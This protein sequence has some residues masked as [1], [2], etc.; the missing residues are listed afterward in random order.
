MIIK[1][2]KLISISESDIKKGV[3]VIPNKVTEINDEVILDFDNLEKVIAKGV[4]TI[5]NYNFRYCNALT[6]IDIPLVTTIGNDNF[7]YCNAL[8]SI[9]IP[10]VTTIGNDNFRYCNAL[11]SIDIPL[12]TTIGNDNFRYCNALTSIDIPL[13]TT[14][15]NYNFYECNALTSIDIPL[16]TTIGNDNFYECNALTSIDIPL[17]TTIGNDNFYECNALTSIKTKKYDLKIKCVDKIPFVIENE[18]TTKGI[19]IYSGFNFSTMINKKLHKDSCYVAEKENFTAHG[20]TIK[21]AIS[22]VQFKIVAEKLKNEPINEDTK[23]TV[24]HY[25][26]ITGAC[27]LGCRDFMRENNIPFVIKDGKTVEKKPIKAKD[28]FEL[29]KTQK[30]YGFEK[31][32]QLITF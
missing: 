7:R 1:N 6:S 22:D 27:D 14:I 20:E 24:K 12:V 15:G 10:L 5:G 25:R 19:K 11:T 30:P 13:V 32:K 16:V 29:M 4:T 8:T 3:L 26:L 28:L 18:K 23:I 9:D 2:K 31:F 17:V 21:Q